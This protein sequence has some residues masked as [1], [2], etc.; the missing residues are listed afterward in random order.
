M[1]GAIILT[2]FHEDD[3]KRQDIFIQTWAS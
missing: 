2:C 1:V 3:V